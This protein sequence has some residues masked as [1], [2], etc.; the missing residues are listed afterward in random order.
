MCHKLIQE[1]ISVRDLRKQIQQKTFER[2]TTTNSQLPEVNHHLSG[3]FK[4]PYLIYW[5][6]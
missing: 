4:D 5:I 2:A 3:N 1:K 6:F